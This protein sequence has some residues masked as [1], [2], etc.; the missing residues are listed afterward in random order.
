[1]L[2]GRPSFVPLGQIAVT[3]SCFSFFVCIV[4]GWASGFTGAGGV[5][6]CL[7]VYSICYVQF[8]RFV[9]SLRSKLAKHDD[10]NAQRVLQVC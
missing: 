10:G 4:L 6:S 1:M 8:H 5:G 2:D 7:Y 9:A 3:H